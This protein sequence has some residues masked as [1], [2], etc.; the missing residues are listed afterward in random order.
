MQSSES[1][2]MDLDE[3]VE[4]FTLSV[5]VNPSPA[6]VATP[7]MTDVREPGSVDLKRYSTAM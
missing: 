4:S 3:M 2:G 5:T 7:T 6:F 1:T